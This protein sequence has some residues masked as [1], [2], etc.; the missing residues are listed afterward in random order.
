MNRLWGGP[1]VS[2][3][4][5]PRRRGDEPMGEPRGIRNNYLFNPTF[6]MDC[7]TFKG[8]KMDLRFDWRP[9]PINVI[10]PRGLVTN[11]VC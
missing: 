1:R 5:V 8:G 6:L 2:P 4:A 11:S 10:A 7:P 9:L 3:A